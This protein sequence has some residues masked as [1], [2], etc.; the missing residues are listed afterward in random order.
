MEQSLRLHSIP[1]PRANL[2]GPR[3]EISHLEHSS[4]LKWAFSL[5]GVSDTEDI[6]HM[7]GKDHSASLC[8]LM[9]HAPVA[10]HVLESPVHD[11]VVEHL[12][13]YVSHLFQPIDAFHRFHRPI[14]FTWFFEAS[15]LFQVC[16]LI[17]GQYPMQKCSF[18]INLLDVPTLCH[19]KVEDGLERLELCSQGH[20][21]VVVDTV[22]LGITF[23]DIPDL[24]VYNVACIIPFS[25]ANKFS[26]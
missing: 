21:F 9:V 13:P 23:C 7:D 26:F 24:V 6:I 12:V 8:V 1:M 14:I 18:D 15:W 2:T 4:A 19:S 16:C 11:S 17:F 3:S 5:G 25:F 22:F 20:P 10:L